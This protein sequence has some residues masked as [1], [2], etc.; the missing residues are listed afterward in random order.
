MSD[1][2][3]QEQYLQFGYGLPF[4]SEM[5]AHALN[6]VDMCAYMCCQTRMLGTAICDPLAGCL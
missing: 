5:C 4:D 6:S 3:F 2:S 1:E